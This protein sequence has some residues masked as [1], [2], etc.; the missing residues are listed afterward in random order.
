[1]SV[2]ASISGCEY[3]DGTNSAQYV[4]A[5]GYRLQVCR[6]DTSP[7]DARIAR[8]LLVAGM[9]EVIQLQAIGNVPDVMLIA[10]YVARDFSAARMKNGVASAVYRTGPE[11]AAG[12]C[13]FV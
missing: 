9:A 13:D 3:G 12:R 7:M 6:I 1:M 8:A 2:A 10:P 5:V 11:P 4:F